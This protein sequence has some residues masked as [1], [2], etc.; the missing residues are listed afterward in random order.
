[1]YYIINELGYKGDLFDDYDS[2]VGRFRMTDTG[3]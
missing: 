3:Y 2:F 1:M